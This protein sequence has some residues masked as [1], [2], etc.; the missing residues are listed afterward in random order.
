MSR[1]FIGRHMSI[2]LPDH[3]SSARIRFTASVGWNSSHQ[4]WFVAFLHAISGNRH[5][6]IPPYLPRPQ[7]A[8]V[9]DTKPVQIDNKGG[10][11]HMEL[12]VKETKKK[13]SVKSLT[14]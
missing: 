14:L 12:S 10:Y 11:Q 6:T 8:S 4:T 5:I 3:T 7:H 9:V 2:C 13:Y 1:K